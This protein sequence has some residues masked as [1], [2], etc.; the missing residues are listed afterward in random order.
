MTALAACVT[1]LADWSAVDPDPAAAGYRERQIAQTFPP[2]RRREWLTGRL[3]ARAALRMARG[4]LGEQVEILRDSRSGAPVVRGL[5]PR[6]PAT[7]SLSHTGD[8]VVCVAVTGEAQVGVDIERQ[9]RRNGELMRRIAGPDERT[10]PDVDPTLLWSVKEAAF[11]AQVSG[12]ASLKHYRVD[13]TGAQ[14]TVVLKLNGRAVRSSVWTFQWDDTVVAVVGRGITAPAVA[15][16]TAQADGPSI[17]RTDS[18][19]SSG[20]LA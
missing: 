17:S 6:S 20:E 14:P 5:P 11:K 3:T 7:I 13:W 16:L 9:D 12:P 10:P 8:R 1:V 4:G 18:I 15:V 2:W 19:L